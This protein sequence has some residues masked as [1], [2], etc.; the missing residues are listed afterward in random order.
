MEDDGVA[1]G[2]VQG[3]TDANIM[4]INPA[5]CPGFV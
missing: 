2:D 3:F 1:N 4:Q 5:N